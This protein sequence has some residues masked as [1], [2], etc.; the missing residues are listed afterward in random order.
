MYVYVVEYI[1]IHSNNHPDSSHRTTS[2]LNT[3]RLQSNLHTVAPMP[4]STTPCFNIAQAVIG[5]NTAVTTLPLKNL[6]AANPWGSVSARAIIRTNTVHRNLYRYIYRLW[7]NSA[8]RCCCC[9]P[10][11]EHARV[12]AH[13]ATGTFHHP[14]LITGNSLPK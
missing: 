13:L 8:F 5:T 1:G 11:D 6:L 3:T 7:Y 14:S 9:N 4:K 2:I 10:T 12:H